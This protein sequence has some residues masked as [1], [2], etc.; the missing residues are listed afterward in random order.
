MDRNQLEQAADGDAVTILE[1]LFPVT[2][3]QQPGQ[4]V[5]LLLRA[6]RLPRRRKQHCERKATEHERGVQVDRATQRIERFGRPVLLLQDQAVHIVARGVHRVTCDGGFRRNA[7]FVEPD[8][9]RKDL[10]FDIRASGI[11]DVGARET[12]QDLKGVC[13]AA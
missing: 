2:I 8:E 1:Q 4:R 9:A 3:V 10:R 13:N 12:I 5:K 11:A 7:G 6:R